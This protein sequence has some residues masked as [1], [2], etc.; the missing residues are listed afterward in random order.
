[1]PTLEQVAE[2]QRLK[3]SGE[4]DLYPSDKKAKAM[5]IYEPLMGVSGGQTQETTKSGLSGL[6]KEVST[7]YPWAP[8]GMTAMVPV[9]SVRKTITQSPVLNQLSSIFG[10][11]TTG[12]YEPQKPTVTHNIEGPL[13]FRKELVNE[14]DKVIN[15]MGRGTMIPLVSQMLVGRT[16]IKL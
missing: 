5:S 8:Q 13:T 3:S 11:D 14:A 4:L 12:G 15:M 16:Y 9:G 7:D 2:Y 10:L 6:T 1:M